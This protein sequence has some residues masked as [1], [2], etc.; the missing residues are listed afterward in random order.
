MSM[1]PSE[2]PAFPQETS[3]DIYAVLQPAREV[4]GDFYDF[5]MLDDDHLCFVI[6]DVSDKGAAA[7][8][9][10]AMARSVIKAA[11]RNLAVRQRSSRVPTATC[12]KTTR[13]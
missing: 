1:L 3:F 10:M 7:A 12:R 5:F 4:G 8:L 6:A 11:A 9:F 2:F 13:N